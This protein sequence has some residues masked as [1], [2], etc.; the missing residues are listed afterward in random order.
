MISDKF[1]QDLSGCSFIQHF[2]DSALAV[3]R[4]ALFC[5][6][7][8]LCHTGEGGAIVS[9]GVH[10]YSTAFTRNHYACTPEGMARLS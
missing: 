2:P 1:Y 7:V 3:H 6:P 10:V 8:T 4:A 9:R 5:V